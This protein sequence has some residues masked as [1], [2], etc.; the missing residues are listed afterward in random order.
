MP[1]N[2]KIVTN[3]LHEKAE[4]VLDDGSVMSYDNKED[5][6]ADCEKFKPIVEST[7][8]EPVAES[9]PVEG[10]INNE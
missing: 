10:V 8:V 7:P 6:L 3:R 2:R 9:P 5:Y 1:D 4:L